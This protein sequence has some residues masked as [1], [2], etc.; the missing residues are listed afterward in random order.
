MNK[1][2]EIMG[3][4]MEFIM[5]I[6]MF[7]IVIL[8]TLGRTVAVLVLLSVMAMMYYQ[9]TLGFS[10]F[11]DG[12]FQ[13][14]HS[15]FSGGILLASSLS[16]MAIVLIGRTFCV[17]SSVFLTIAT[18]FGVGAA[19][20]QDLDIR[21]IGA[22]YPII[23]Q[24]ALDEIEQASEGVEITLEDFGDSDGW[25]ATQSH[26]L[27]VATEN[28]IR[29]V[30]P[31][32]ELPFDI[33]DKDGNILYPKGFTF[34]P[35][36]HLTLPNVLWIARPEHLDW[37]FSMADDFDMILM[38]GGNALKESEARR[39]PVFMLEAKLAERMNLEFSPA[40]VWQEGSVLKVQEFDL[41][42]QSSESDHVEVS[43]GSEQ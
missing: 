29:D 12:I 25:T 21:Q 8:G 4:D 34:N 1:L 31:F 19:S 17:A 42:S 30:I 18:I 37:A 20:A 28:R 36:E 27:P 10:F 26:I 13:S 5:L 16:T 24:D 43:G 22:V 39:H 3:A 23:E 33:P 38:A 32:F 40:R 6:A 14:G 2:Q 41:E 11:F 35:M 15:D 7:S 9:T